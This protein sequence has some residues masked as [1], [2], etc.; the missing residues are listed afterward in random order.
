MDECRAGDSESS[1]SHYS[2]LNHESWF[3]I[4][5]VRSSATNAPRLSRARLPGRRHAGARV[6]HSSRAPARGD[7]ESV[8]QQRQMDGCGQSAP[9]SAQGQA[10]HLAFDGGRA[11]ASR[12]IRSQAEAGRDARQ[13]DA[14]KHDEGETARA[15]AG[16]GAV[17]LRPATQ[18]Q[19]VREVRRGD[20]RAVRTH[21]LGGGRPL[22]HPLDDHRS[23]QS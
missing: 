4:S 10:D 5:S 9:F 8:R 15:V 13:A 18:V 1:R 2:F 3:R 6:A 21:R 11:V 19:E 17:V 20:L 23:D 12:N 7:C 16:Q 22:H 14:R